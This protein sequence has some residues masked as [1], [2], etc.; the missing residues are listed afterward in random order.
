M[1][2]RPQNRTCVECG[3]P[4][5]HTDFAYHAGKIE[6]GP[7]YWSDR[8]LLCSAA[9]STAHYE[10]RE[11]AGDAMKEPAPDPFERG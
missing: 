7:S 9:C 4:Y 5:G 3:R 11:K 6:N 1:L 8:G 10:K 2:N